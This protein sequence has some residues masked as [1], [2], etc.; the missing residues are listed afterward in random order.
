MESKRQT[1]LVS[2]PF[3]GLPLSARTAVLFTCTVAAASI[4][5]YRHSITPSSVYRE[6][7]LHKLRHDR[8]Q[9]YRL[10]AWALH[11]VKDK[12][13]DPTR[14]HPR[15]MLLW[16]LDG[17][18]KYV[19]E[20]MVQPNLAE[21]RVT[22]KVD[23]F[24]RDFSTS[25]V[26]S[27]SALY[28]SLKQ[29][30]SFVRRHLDP[31]TGMKMVEYAAINGLLST[32]DPHSLWL[33]PDVYRNMKAGT[34]G[35]FGGLGIV[36]SIRDGMLTVVSPIDDTP[37]SRAG[38]K[39]QDRIVKI[40]NESTINMSL[41]EAVNRLRGD[42]NTK[43]TLWISRAG[44][45]EP[46]KF[47]IVRDIIRIKS[48]SSRMLSNG[49]GYLRIKHFS[50][51]MSAEM[52]RHL[53]K[54]KQKGA[55]ALVLDLFNNPGGLLE[56]AINAADLFLSDGEIVTVVAYA[57]T[58]RETAK[59]RKSTTIW[60]EPVVVLV[61]SGSASAAEVLAGALK[62]RDRAVVVGQRTFGKG[63]VQVLFEYDEGSALK[64]TVRQYLT[65]GGVSIQSVGI[66][67]D[68][69]LLPVV[70]KPGQVLFNRAIPS[71]REQDLEQHLSQHQLLKKENAPAAEIYYLSKDPAAMEV[72][73]TEMSGNAAD[74]SVVRVAM[75]L[76]AARLTGSREEVL[77][78]MSP[79]LADFREK[80]EKRIVKALTKLNVD[81]KIEPASEVPMLEAVVE[82]DKPDNLVRPGDTIRLKVTVTNMGQGP[83]YRVRAVTSADGDHFDNKEFIFGRIDPGKQRTWEVPILIPQQSLSQV[84]PVT[85]T[86][87][88]EYGHQPTKTVLAIRIQGRKRALF[89]CQYQIMDDH[90]G[91]RDGLAQAGESLRLRVLVRNLG[92]GTSMETLLTIKNLSGSA[93]FI[94]KGR[95]DIGGLAPGEE[96][97]VDFKLDIRR[98]TDAR[99]VEL[100]LSVSDPKL[101]V[102]VQDRVIIPIMV[103]SRPPSDLDGYVEVTTDQA[104]LR[105]GADPSAP[106][107]GNIRSKGILRLLGKIH[108]YYRVAWEEDRFG[109][110][111]IQ[112]TRRLSSDKL[113]SI[114]ASIRRHFHI[115]PPL[116]R[117]NPI[118]LVTTDDHVRVNGIALDDQEVKDVYMEVGQWRGRSVRKKTYYQSN[119]SGADPRSLSFSAKVPL[120]KGLNYIKVVARQNN[121]CQTEKVLISLRRSSSHQ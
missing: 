104:E 102:Q 30:L 8:S 107:L 91:N 59:A 43:V 115:T 82:S 51:G 75:K 31:K 42:P 83:A 3:Q 34:R 15:R 50:L 1:S 89:A 18:Q 114:N 99:K 113:T 103:S 68:I 88:E 17:I 96:K 72:S 109:F 22:V 85:F 23:A 16:A 97:S 57:G 47:V 121:H 7:S 65:P 106:L 2:K 71:I 41:N 117:L 111:S 24:R 28:G 98:D 40:G 6:A 76:L 93:V 12:Y 33:D 120:Q 9:Q 70:V 77:K 48:V 38:L 56:E 10:T 44:W 67:P 79:F 20:V 78:R 29:I 108:G 35:S 110:I 100:R 25:D 13:V 55:R 87:F 84:H 26:T 118:P 105:G 5:Y 54:L 90:L 112:N 92:P 46:R 60:K 74:P 53:K 14:I 119:R 36:I 61:N 81:W 69:R 64:L 45:A 73:P 49:V 11:M 80:E 116:V 27:I 66:N 58:N 63:S 101:G 62:G 32:L 52:A 95:F 37:A 94:R 86:F 19:A 39:T 21:Q 4:T